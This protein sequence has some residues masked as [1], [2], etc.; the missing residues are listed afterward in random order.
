M[1]DTPALAG[2]R[3]HQERTVALLRDIIHIP[4]LSGDE[5]AVVA[6]LAHEMRE[7]RF[8]EV[9]IDGYGSVIGRIGEGPVPIVFDSHIDTVNV[10]SRSE[11][12]RDPFEPAI[13][14]DEHDGVV[15]GRGA[16][17]NKAGIAAMIHGAALARDLDQ[18]QGT[19]LYV[20]GSVQEEVCDGLALEHMIAHL[21]ARPA[22]VVL[23]EATGCRL[24]RG[25]RGRIEASVTV[26]GV[27]CHASA[28]DRG[29]NPVYELA[30]VA[31]DIEVLNRRLAFD[32]FLG[33]GT[34]AVTKI[35]CETPSLNAVPSTATLY[36]DRRLTVGETPELALAELAELASVK[37]FGA[38]VE[39]LH[40]DLVSYTGMQLERDKAF[41]TW[42]TAEDDRAVRAGLATGF[43]A[44]DRPLPVG[45]WV[46]STNG[47]ASMG[48]LGIPTIGFGPADEIH[49]HTAHDQCPADQL[50][51]AV[52]WYSAFPL[53]YASL[54]GDDP[55]DARTEIG[56]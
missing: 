48:K 31:A 42:V 44:L 45:S 35:I 29:T 18:I 47:V 21:P 46:F 6:R 12:S 17:D 30:A 3:Q 14:G 26:R 36:V 43:A 9:L 41:A 52:A 1:T 23:G 33:S 15:H 24:Y 56:A 16:S 53:A 39:L 2:A 4:S 7:L 19:T 54:L 34:I 5:E 40:H 28:P 25:H 55:G 10:G 22:V 20:V 38:E 50:G 13:E 8:D 37:R 49:A 51:E 11:W 32:E 27:S